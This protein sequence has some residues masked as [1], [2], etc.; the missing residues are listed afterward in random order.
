[1]SR[2]QET[3]ELVRFDSVS[4]REAAIAAHVARRL[5]NG[6]HL[7]VER[8]GDNVVASTNGS[9]RQRVIVAGHLDTVPGDAST[10]Q[11][12]GDRVV[13]LGACDMKGSLAVMI[14]EALR[15]VPRDL[16]VTWIFYA[17]EEISR[18]LSGLLE[19]AELRP[20]LLVADAAVL[21]EPT[22]G[23]VEAGCQ[24]SLRIAMRLRGSR[25]HTA[26]PFTG[27]NAI[28]RLG[29]VIARVADYEPRSVTID[30]VTFCEQMQV[31]AAGGGVAANVVPDEA[32]CTINHRVAPDRQLDGALAAFRDLVGDLVEDDDEIEVEDYAPPAP[33]SLSDA[34]LER[35]VAASGVAPRAKVGWTD[36]ATFSELGIPA[37][38][39]GAGDPLLAHSSGE[40]VSAEELAVFQRG[41]SAYLSGVSTP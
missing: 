33:P 31:V 34:M 29:A 12:V 40:F 18:P 28:H 4:G 24:G 16:D 17:R 20:E 8:V 13:G 26:R 6:K 2:L 5:S 1:V 27:R 19:L 3:L 39:F 15:N 41:L 11:I 36:V 37:A 10:A 7:A 35:L 25:A 32:H 38:N 30:G 22:G 21:A 14:D 9:R 23:V